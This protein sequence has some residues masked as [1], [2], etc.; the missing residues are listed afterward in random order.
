MRR[1]RQ[2]RNQGD[3]PKHSCERRTRGREVHQVR[4]S[5]RTPRDLREGVLTED[6]EIWICPFFYLATFAGPFPS[7]PFLASV[8]LWAVASC[9]ALLSYWLD[10][11]VSAAGAL[12]LAAIFTFADSYLSLVLFIAMLM[13]YAM[14]LRWGDPIGALVMFPFIAQKGIQILIEEG[15]HEYVED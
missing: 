1:A 11:A 4:C 5:L 8:R 3:H 12:V 6:R 2:R 14:N 10:A 13:S 7:F 15:K 9:A